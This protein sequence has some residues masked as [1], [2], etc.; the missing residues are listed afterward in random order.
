MSIIDC[1]G[2][3]TAFHAEKVTLG[4]AQQDEMRA[5]RDAGRTRLKTGLE[6]DDHAPPDMHAQGSYAMRTMTQDPQN[7]YDID[8]GAYFWKDDLKD[9]DGKDLAPLAARQRVCKALKRDDRL[10]NGAIVKTNCVR[11]PYPEGYHIDIPVYRVTKI[12]DASGST[13]KQYEHS[14]GDNWTVSDARAVTRWFNGLVGELN[15]GQSDGSQM[16]RVTKLTKKQARSRTPWK[17]QTTSG[18]CMTK[19]VVDHFVQHDREDVALR[20]TWKKIHGALQWSLRVAHPVIVGGTLAQEG[21]AEVAFFR[22]RLGEALKKLEALD[23]A[24]CTRKKAR[25]VWDDVFNTSFF[26]DRPVHDDDDDGGGKGRTAFGTVSAG[27]ERRNDG[28]RRF[29]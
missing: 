8:D 24:V 17:A 15:A 22:D 4:K 18:I 11:Q 10:K 12:E 20:E 5:R 21:D 28:G 9:A 7:D 2:E 25:K 16:R 23:A 26:S 14:S 6:R 27:V 1:S 13:I 19:L 3:M 29:G